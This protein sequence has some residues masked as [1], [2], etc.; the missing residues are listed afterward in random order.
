MGAY[1]TIYPQVR[2]RKTGEL[3][4]SQLFAD[5]KK[6]VGYKNAREIYLRV[7]SA[8][9]I[10]GHEEELSRD[11][12]GEYT[13]RSL[14]SV[15]ELAPLLGTR[16]RRSFA[17]KEIN[18]Y[19]PVPATRENVLDAEK[20][21][22]KY[23][24]TL[25]DEFVALTELYEDNEGNDIVQVKLVENNPENREKASRISRKQILVSRLDN[26]MKR[27]GIEEDVIDIIM[28]KMAEN[29]IDEYDAAV[30]IAENLQALVRKANGKTGLVYMPEEMSI[31]TFAA[32]LDT[33]LMNRLRNALSKRGMAESILGEDGYMSLPDDFRDDEAS[34]IEAAIGKLIADYVLDDSGSSPEIASISGLVSRI[35]DQFNEI[36][37]KIGE[38]E[39]SSYIRD[40]KRSPITS[41][42][43]DEMTDET[44]IEFNQETDT[45]EFN[46]LRGRIAKQQDLLH[47]IIETNVRRF[48][49][50]SARDTD[51][52]KTFDKS[53]TSSLYARFQ[54]EEYEL[55]IY[56]FVDATLT[57]LEK[58]ESVIMELR[59]NGNLP[60]EQR[61]KS[62]K[63][64]KDFIESY[65]ISI[66]AIARAEFAG[67]I[68]PNQERKDIL[69][70]A[71][72]MIGSL[73]AAYEQLKNPILV[74]FVKRFVGEGL[75]IPFG[76]WNGKKKGDIIT[77]EE[78][79]EQA[80]K[81]ITVF[82]RWLDSM[83]ESGDMMLRMLDA[84]AKKARSAARLETI[85][86]KK[87][88]DAAYLKLRQ[89]GIT[90]T[91]FM[92]ARD[93]NGHK[94][95]K[96]ISADQAERLDIAR[97]NYYK[98]V[99][100][101]KREL[102]AKL[103]KGSTTEL[104]IVRVRK[105]FIE[106]L[107][108][109]DSINGIIR[110]TKEA[111]RD[112]VKRR[113]DNPETDGR[114]EIEGQD[115]GVKKTVLMDFTGKQVE[116]LPIM[117]VNS[118]DGE[119]LDDIS[120]DVTSSMLM[121]A[122]MSCNFSAMN[123]V[124]GLLELVREKINERPVLQRAGTK[125][126]V[127]VLQAFGITVETDLTKSGEATNIVRRMNDWFSSQVYSRYMK[128]EGEI[129]GMDV[130]MLAN[131]SN[132]VTA[133][134]QFALNILSGISN[135]MT[136]SAMNRIES[137]AGQFFSVKNLAKAD[138]IFWSALPDFLG[139]VGQPVKHSKLALFMEKF[140]TMQDFE[141]DVRGQEYAKSR[142][143]RLLNSNSLYV[144]NNAG[145]LWI[146]NRAVLA[147]SEAYGLRDKDNNPISL[148]D[149]QEVVTDKNGV[150]RLVTKPGIKKAD[151]TAFDDNVDVMKFTNKAKSINQRMNGI[152]NYEDRC[153]AQ[154]Y[155]WGRIGLMFRKWIKPSL[156][157]R[158]SSLNYN[159][160]VEEW[161][162]GFYTTAGRFFSQ[163]VKDL[164][165][166]QFDIVTSYKNLDPREQANLMR[167][168]VEVGQF[169]S[170]CAAFAILKD[171]KK[172]ADDDDD[173][174]AKSW[175]FNQ[176]LYQTRR[177]ESEIG[178]QM[179]I[180]PQMIQEAFNILKS[181]AACVNTWEGVT[182]MAQLMIPSNYTKILQTG[183][184][185][186][187][188]KAYKLFW[189]SPLIPMHRTIYR[190]LHPQNSLQFYDL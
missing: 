165:R 8:D 29:G 176:L 135:V 112:K 162:E 179:I 190:G 92:F 12:N 99:M 43:E 79:L 128:D 143:A 129:L 98:E 66:D 141:S 87:R 131:L 140:N 52:D 91:S 113:S 155:A 169:V 51:Y 102:D 70:Q 109:Q 22:M 181:P 106:R 35:R 68:K 138:S 185:K 42:L 2:S 81:D 132:E 21:A 93:P 65:R 114:G 123:N 86:Y 13:L 77:A 134:N 61:A 85:E 80:E 1:C 137:I 125:P 44:T 153:A 75:E 110:E 101:I 166:G 39:I 60:L 174:L 82:D 148:W 136:A 168:A 142:F 59:D 19:Q 177:L 3:V 7:R 23:N 107:K 158:Y 157:R 133:L 146:Q 58:A 120:E 15:P 5:L 180:N 178:S 105:D 147:L 47:D 156:N 34:V 151:G 116:I 16:I 67:V 124:V 46:N 4:N 118:K 83:A 189:D 171:V 186:G 104:N 130:G 32:I 159:F 63:N 24:S 139:D 89:S 64:I 117:F 100:S 18:A 26:A 164:R 17:S 111:L 145:E 11:E 187:H 10:D 161:E 14:K 90:D 28:D 73:T 27:I 40:A 25:H 56:D 53:L 45:P 149:S 108:G 167:F 33:P 172:K 160:D 121:Y 69:N 97:K 115:E 152:Y 119:S 144:I 94:T 175:W 20:R 31:I 37:F 48:K 74:S 88:L 57:Q 71:T 163:L 36:I 103:P 9:F 173:N 154:A 49:I 96:Y 170:V 84:T 6:A 183:R 41:Q 62:L 126:L 122:N 72:Y 38:D 188:S 184:Y 150:S 76:T 55:G 50:L 182:N 30:Y 95:G 54:D 78:L 127:N